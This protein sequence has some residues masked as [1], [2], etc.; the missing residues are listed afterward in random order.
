MFEKEDIILDPRTDEIGKLLIEL[1]NRTGES[2]TM[3]GFA[4]PD[5]AATL[6]QRAT[7]YSMHFPRPTEVGSR[8]IVN[9]LNDPH[10][11]N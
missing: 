3:P 5:N 2:L 6:N 7:L 8:F 9:P 1:C 4:H 10:S 11:S